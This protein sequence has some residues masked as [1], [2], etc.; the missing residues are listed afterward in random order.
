VIDLTFTN[1][2]ASRARAI[3]GHYI[4]MEI[5]CLSDH[6]A[7]IF[8]IGPPREMVTN[9]CESKLNWKHASEEEFTKALKEEITHENQKVENLKGNL[10][11][12]NRC[13]AFPE[14]L[15][16]AT[17]IIHKIVENATAKSV[18]I[19]R[20]SKALKPWWNEDLTKSYRELRQ[21]RDALRGWVKDFNRPSVYLVDKVKSL[22]KDICTQIRKAKQEHYRKLTEEANPGNMWDFRKWTKCQRTYISPPLINGTDRP[23]VEHKD[24]CNVLRENLFPQPPPLPEAPAINLTP[25]NEDMEYVSVTKREVHDTIFT[26]AQLN[27]PGISGLMG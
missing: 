21:T 25:R 13:T 22:Q 20:P 3:S 6:H 1:A 16:E 5:G 11:N 10:L 26:A 7:T 24:K 8:Q 19:R 14:E 4:D 12:V 23:A 2:A 27:A 9:P 15:E 18:P 17:A